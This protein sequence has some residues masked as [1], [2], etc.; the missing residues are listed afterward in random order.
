M[1]RDSPYSS[2]QALLVTFS[3]VAAH[4]SGGDFQTLPFSGASASWT[5]DL[6]RLNGTED[7]LGTG[8]LPAGHYTQIRLT[9]TSATLYFDNPST[10]AI[11]AASVPV[12]AGASAPVTVPSGTVYVNGQFDVTADQTTTI[13]LDFNGDQSVRLLGDGSYEMTPVIS[14]VSVQ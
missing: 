10:G 1:L 2:A 13:H 12:P 7:L 14:V 9:I 8:A 3:A 11:C 4:T 5:C 6:K